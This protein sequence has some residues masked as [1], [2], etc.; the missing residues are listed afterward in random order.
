MKNDWQQ[1]I[2]R[3]KLNGVMI[4]ITMTMIV[5]IYRAL[6]NSAY[7]QQHVFI[8]ATH[9]QSMDQQ[10]RSKTLSP[11]TK[12]ILPT[13][14]QRLTSKKARQSS[15]KMIKTKTTSGM[16]TKRSKQH[17]EKAFVQPAKTQP[18]IMS[19]GLTAKPIEKISV[20]IQDA[21]Q[22]PIKSVTN[23]VISYLH[24]RGAH[25]GPVQGRILTSFI[26]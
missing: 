26:V 7:R 19:T 25:R 11:D 1:Q 17:R 23:A 15:T 12:L 8:A 13:N 6:L 9:S 18:M 2:Q 21:K 3:L 10:S 16:I 4:S 24:Y 22:T 14:Q 20:P 5:N